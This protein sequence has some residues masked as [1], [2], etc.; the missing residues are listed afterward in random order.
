MRNIKIP[1]NRIRKLRTL[2][3]GDKK[4]YL[5]TINK[6]GFKEKLIDLCSNDYF[7]LS[8]DNEVI[9]AAHKSSRIEG[10][11]SGSSLFI[12]GSRPV[13]NTL[14]KEIA[15]W[16]DREKVLLFPSG[17]QANIAAIQALANRNTIVIADKYIHNSLITGIK[18][19]GGKLI[20]FLHNNLSD[21][22]NKLTK[23]KP[24]RKSLLVIIESLYSMEGSLAP[25]NKIIKLCNKY[26][27]K[28]IIDEAH[29]LGIVGNFGKGLSYK[30]K[31]P[32]QI[33][34]GTF[35]KAFGSGGAFLACDE[36]TCEK[37]IQ[38]SSAFRYT[39]ALSP[40]LAAGALSSL[41]K[42]KN[43]KYWGRDLLA[44]SH[45]WKEEIRNVTN[46][47]VIGDCHIISI[48]IGSEDDTLLMQKYLEKN[49]F[50]AIAIRP[51]TI[52]VGESRIRITVKKTLNERILKDFVSVLK[53]FK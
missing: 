25:L 5:E 27:A 41:Q 34:C 45:K 14:E 42:I 37:I 11:G 40:A 50:L 46:Y 10:L 44:F 30:L 15:K 4:Y 43:N 29:A 38:T 35:G 33:V 31:D 20:R 12:S 1:K 53:D 17:F 3:I 51:P 6:K 32:I 49:G 21:L 52:P 16:L 18:A 23:F 24:E 36:E 2:S 39:T 22:E 8:R 47:S 9:E 7:G 26:N 48:I 19:S 28:L 13:H